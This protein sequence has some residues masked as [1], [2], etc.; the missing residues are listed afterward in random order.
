MQRVSLQ[1]NLMS[2]RDSALE[3]AKVQHLL[4]EG[5]EIQVMSVQQR[6]KHRARQIDRVTGEINILN[7]SLKSEW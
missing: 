5:I 3:R 4:S 1:W 6:S 2:P 7:V